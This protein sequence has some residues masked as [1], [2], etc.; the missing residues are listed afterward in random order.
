MRELKLPRR[1]DE[2]SYPASTPETE[3]IQAIILRAICDCC[4][5]TSRRSSSQQSRNRT[6][7][8]IAY[9]RDARE[10]LYSDS[11]QEWSFLWCV[12]QVVQDPVRARS[13]VKTIRLRIPLLQKEFLQSDIPYRSVFVRRI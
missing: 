9:A 4:P 1:A 8:E 12:E 3:L 5:Q 2:V 7:Q 6:S 10:W 11:L 13:C